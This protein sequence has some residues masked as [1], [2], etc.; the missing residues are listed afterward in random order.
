MGAAQQ[1]SGRGLGL[2]HTLVAGRETP[3]RPESGLLSNSWKWVVWW[4]TQADKAKN[5]IGKRCLDW[6]QEVKGHWEVRSAIWLSVLGFMV[7]GLVSGLYLD[8]YSDSESFP[9]AHALLSQ[10][11]WQREGFWEVLG[12]VAS[13]FDLSWTLSVGG[14]LLVPCSLLGPS[15]I[16]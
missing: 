3:S 10:D 5:F 8:N 11:G 9:V 14:G 7:M 6:E 4:D 16:K 1:V 15:V 12:H 13:P 2:Q